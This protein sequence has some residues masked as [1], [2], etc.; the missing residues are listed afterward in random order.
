MPEASGELLVSDIQM[1]SSIQPHEKR[2]NDSPFIKNN[3]RIIP[4]PYASVS[5]KR[6]VYLYFEVN[7]LLFGDRGQTAYTVDYELRTKKSGLAKI[8]PFSG[9]KLALSSSYQRNGQKRNE[10]EYFSLDV[11]KMKPGDYT[12]TVRV[13]DEMARE[14]RESAIILNVVE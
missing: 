3:L 6:P 5:G 7:N 13:M 12:L 2:T 11:A 10:Q 14:S 8:N 4:Y 9:K 1:A